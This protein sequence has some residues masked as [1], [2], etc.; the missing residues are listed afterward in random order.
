MED[1]EGRKIYL[2]TR[3]IT[4]RWTALDGSTSPPSLRNNF[5][6]MPCEKACEKACK[7]T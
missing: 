1:L 5:A 7:K 4:E 3:R 6:A 2:D